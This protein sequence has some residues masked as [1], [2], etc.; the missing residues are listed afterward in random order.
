MTTPPECW[1]V[2]LASLPAVGPARLRALLGSVDAPADWERVWDG[3]RRGTIDPR[4]IVHPPASGIESIR[5]RWRQAANAIDAVAHW[6]AHV[7]AGL[8][9]LVHGTDDY[10]AALVDDDDPPPVVFVRGDPGALARPRVAIVGT[11]RASRYG[12][13]VARALGADL[14]R[15]GVVVV[16]GL[17]LGI[18]G[19]AHS[20]VLEAE[21]APPVAVVGSGLDRVYPRSNRALWSQV[22]ERGAVLAEYPLGV[23]AAAWQFP[24][25]NR[26][27]AALSDVVVVVESQITGG[28]LGTAIEAARRGRTVFAV[29]GPVTAP[30]SAGTNQLLHDGCPPARDATDVL[31]ALGLSAA[32]GRSAEARRPSPQGDAA[33]VLQSLPW[34][35]V[36]VEDVVVDTGLGLGPVVLAL[37]ELDRDGWIVQRSG[38]VERVAR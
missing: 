15:A 37:D 20:G 5:T 11:R 17:A 33:R 3:V 24:A 35:A 2:A 16:S 21:G 29:P 32:P 36:P 9:V 27:I 13:D 30:S 14:A 28:A 6:Q 19:A 26:I 10:P 22:A 34:H 12:L 23:P 8:H 1:A 4:C 25:R 38:W 31:V 18:D 7:D